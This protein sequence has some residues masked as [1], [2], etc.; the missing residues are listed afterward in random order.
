[1]VR[2]RDGPDLAGSLYQHLRQLGEAERAGSALED[3]HGKLLESSDGDRRRVALFV[4]MA[5]VASLRG[6]GD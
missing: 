1:M 6:G 2:F 5:E 3:G 4:E